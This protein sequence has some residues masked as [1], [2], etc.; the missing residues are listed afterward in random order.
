MLDVLAVE[1]FD[2]FEEAALSFFEGVNFMRKLLDSV[3]VHVGR[4]QLGGDLVQ[5]GIF[6]GLEPILEG[7]GCLADADAAKTCQH[8]HLADWKL[9]ILLSVG[10]IQEKTPNNRLVLPGET[11]VTQ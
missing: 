10:L 7:E 5:Q 4:Q 3:P 2:G 1:L 9:H 6:D 11:K 8:Q